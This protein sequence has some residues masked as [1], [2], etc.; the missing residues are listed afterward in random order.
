MK[1]KRWGHIYDGGAGMDSPAGTQHLDGE[2]R[3]DLGT[4]RM[5]FPRKISS[6]TAPGGLRWL[7]VTVPDTPIIIWGLKSPSFLL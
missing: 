2:I 6:G 7:V 5:H 1:H 3:A 4:H